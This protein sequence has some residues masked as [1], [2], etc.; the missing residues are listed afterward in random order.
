[1]IDNNGDGDADDLFAGQQLIREGGAVGD[2]FLVEYAGVDPANGDAL[3]TNAEGETVS[4]FPG[5]TSRIVA[6]NPLPDFTGGFGSRF[7]FRGLDASFQFQVALGH[8]L[9]LSES[10]FVE[11]NF[12]SGW[13]QRTTQLDAWTPENM[14]GSFPEGR[15][16]NNGGQHSTR[17]LSDADYLR[18]RN[19]QLGYTFNDLG[20]SSSSLRLFLS[21]QNLLTF[22]DFAGLDPE[23]NGADNNSY[24]SGEIFFSRPQ[25]RV[26]SFGLNLNL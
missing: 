13:N 2:F 1:M 7:S 5:G 23:S 3:F 25:S 6:G 22:T 12:G 26:I 4:T 18:L 24:R 9:Y 15:L 21:G 19:V 20:N 16:S 10:R 11:N 14:D 8:Q 17:F